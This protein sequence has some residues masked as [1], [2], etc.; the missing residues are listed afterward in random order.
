M[1]VDTTQI[2]STSMKNGKF[3]TTDLN[4]VPIVRLLN[5]ANMGRRI[6]IR[7][8]LGTHRDSSPSFSLYPDNHWICYGCNQSGSGAIQYVMSLSGCSFLEACDYLS[9]YV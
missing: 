9:S 5:K 4:N 1:N 6:S 8:P 7:C 2:Q 3:N